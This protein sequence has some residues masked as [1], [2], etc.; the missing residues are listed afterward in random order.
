LRFIIGAFSRGEPMPASFTAQNFTGASPQFDLPRGLY[1]VDFDVTGTPDTGCTMVLETFAP[2][3]SWTSLRMIN[4]WRA[5]QSDLHCVL[6]APNTL[7]WNIS[8]GTCLN[9][10]ISGR[11]GV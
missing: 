3:S 10:T 1:N 9:I 8:G 11:G 5:Q 7:R 4:T 2:P 6:H